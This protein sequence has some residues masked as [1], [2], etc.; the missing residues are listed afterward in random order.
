MSIM[1]IHEAARIVPGPGEVEQE[2]ELDWRLH[3]GEAMPLPLT[4]L[5]KHAAMAV[6][7]VRYEQVRRARKHESKRSAQAFGTPL[8]SLAWR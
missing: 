7:W 3:R 5:V 1:E 6:S 2:A 8:P 4:Q